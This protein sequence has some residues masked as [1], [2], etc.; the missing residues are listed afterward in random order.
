MSTVIPFRP[1]KDYTIKFDTLA[2]RLGLKRPFVIRNLLSLDP[3]LIDDIEDKAKNLFSQMSF[4]DVESDKNLEK[5]PEVITIR[6]D[7]EQE[8]R[9]NAL[10]ES[11]GAGT[12]V[13]VLRNL[14]SGD[15]RTVATICK[16]AKSIPF[17]PKEV[18]ISGSTTPGVKANIEITDL[19]A[20]LFQKKSQEV[21]NSEGH[22]IL[23][24]EELSDAIEE[25][26]RKKVFEFE[27][28]LRSL[29]KERGVTSDIEAKVPCQEEIPSAGL[30]SGSGE[31]SSISRR[32]ADSQTGG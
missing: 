31:P 25:L 6:L 20:E 14:L 10:V 21:F 3:I 28:E 18:K 32:H 12:K 16:K 29:V 13:Q 15:P 19:N 1:G 11:L 8:R 23:S 5:V 24:E 17:V 7:N 30:P 26:V 2:K 4:K 9:F 22:G 27:K